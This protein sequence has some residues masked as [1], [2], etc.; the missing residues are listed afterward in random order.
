MVDAHGNVRDGR[1]APQSVGV[2]V[3]RHAA[4]IGLDH[5]RYSANSLRAGYATSGAAGGAS[6]LRL[7][8][9]RRWKYPNVMAGYVRAAQSLDEHNPVHALGL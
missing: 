3:K 1:M 2:I 4:R 6:T 5:A 9:H 8:E 7:M